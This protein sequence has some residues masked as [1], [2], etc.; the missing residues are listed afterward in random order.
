MFTYRKNDNHTHQVRLLSPLG[1]YPNNIFATED[2]A[3]FIS[4]ELCFLVSPLAPK[5]DFE[6]DGYY[7]EME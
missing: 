3:L 6:D 7:S 4:E 5:T 2:S 1:T